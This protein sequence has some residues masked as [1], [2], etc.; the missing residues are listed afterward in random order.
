MWRMAKALAVFMT[1]ASVKWR[2]EDFVMNQRYYHTAYR[3][4]ASSL[5][6]SCRRLYTMR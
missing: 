4:S 2:A 3:S 6:A 1:R 5:T